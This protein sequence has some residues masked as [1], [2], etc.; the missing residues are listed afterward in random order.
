MEIARDVAKLETVSRSQRQNDVILSG[1]RLKF[2]VE[3]AAEALAQCQAPG[4]IDTAAIRRVDY[5][6]HSARLIKEALEND[7]ILL[8][9]AAQSAIRGSQILDQLLTSR[10]GKS[11]ILHQPSQRAFPLRIEMET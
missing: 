3:L 4:A 10:S 2:E 7:G 9:Q 8:R 11:K 6:L 5:E 1:R